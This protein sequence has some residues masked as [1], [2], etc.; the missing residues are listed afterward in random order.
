MKPFWQPRREPRGFTL[1]EI[2]AVLAIIALLTGMAVLSAGA[3]SAPAEREARRLAATLRLAVDES[4][5]QGR[6]LGL[7]FDSGGY[8][9]LE[10]MPGNPGAG[11]RPGFVWNPISRRGALGPRFWM[12][13]MGLELRING[14]LAPAQALRKDAGPQ[15]VL[16]PEG[17]FTPFSLRLSGGRQADVV[18]RFNASGKLAI[19]AP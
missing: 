19:Q 12:Q 5:L 3:T 10:L 7:K 14:Q 15:V 17:E 4:R 18:L 2:L 1:I 8:S 6:V 9:Y 11:S 16:L 13:P